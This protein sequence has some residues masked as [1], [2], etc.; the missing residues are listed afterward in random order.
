MINENNPVK[1]LHFIGIG[2]IGMSGIAEILLG[3]GHRVTGSD[4]LKTDITAYLEKKGA[5]IYEGHR[6]MHVGDADF[7]VYSSAVS[8]ENPEMKE[9]A[10]R[11]IP[12]IRRAEMLG[13]LMN[14]YY[15][16]GVAGTHGKTTTTS[17]LGDILIAAEKDPTLIIGGR[18]KSLMTNARLGK[19]RILLAEAD[20]YDRSFLALNPRLA[21]MTS[22]ESD[23][24]DIYEG[25]EDIKQT[26]IR[27]AHRLPFDGVLVINNDDKNLADIL[28]LIKRS[29]ITFG[30]NDGAEIRAENIRFEQMKSRFDVWRKEKL[31]GEIILQVPGKHNV[32]NAL[33]AVSAALQLGIGFSIVQTALKKFSGVERRFDIKGQK[34]DIMIVD[35]Y[36]HHPTEVE[37]TLQAVKTA[38]PQHRLIAV[39]QPHLYSRTRDFYREFARSLQIA[40]LPVVTGIYPAREEPIEGVSGKMIYDALIKL[41]KNKAFYIED[42][43][44]LPDRLWQIL[45]KGD[46]LLTLGAGN[47]VEVA[48]QLA[49]RLKNTEKVGTE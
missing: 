46:I 18:I 22:L 29:M 33:A 3:M 37:T 26:F 10:R 2:G 14:R 35:D 11:C 19:G 28:P 32:Y 31:L 6:S 39:F 7:I 40:D 1:T 15:G 21:V 20:E 17:M 5:V 23:H 49:Q 34:N 47:I 30:L 8:A 43:N 25:L 45:R 44:E 48:E 42:K 36:A 24:L 41:G 9:A 4:R 12:L 16:I 13:Q 27:F 38:W